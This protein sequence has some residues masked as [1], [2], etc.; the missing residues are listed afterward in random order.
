MA[1]LVPLILSVVAALAVEATSPPRPISLRR[2][3][4]AI[5]L[6]IYAAITVFWFMFSWRPWLAGTTCAASL[7]MTTT[8]N[9]LKMKVIGEP[10]VFSDIALLRQVPQHPELYYAL[11]LSDVRSISLMLTGLALAVLWY[12]T[13]PALLPNDLAT[14]SLAI[15]ALPLALVTLILAGRLSPARAWFARRFPKPDLD[16]DVRRYGIIATMVAYAFRRD[17]EARTPPPAVSETGPNSQTGDEVFLVLQ[18][19]SFLDPTR[20]GL[21]PLPLIERIRRDSVQYGRLRVS[22]HGAYTMRS[23]HAV[24][25]GRSPEDLGF[26]AFDPY[27]AYGGREPS[28]LARFA[29][30]VGY[31][32]T[33]VHPY[34]RDFFHRAEVISELGFERLLMHEA[35]VAAPRVGPYV[36]DIALAERI[37]AEIRERARPLFLFAVTMENHGPWKEGR[38]PG[39]GEPLTQYAHH[40][41][42]TGRAVEMVIEALRGTRATLCVFGDHPPS[43]PASRPGPDV[44]QTDYAIFAFGRDGG[45]ATPRRID[46]SAP[47]LGLT[48]RAALVG[49]AGSLAEADVAAPRS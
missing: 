42:N 12:L 9:R 13:E 28:S 29:S 17:T 32:T 31:A 1:F 27:L 3:D 19:E 33:F 47:Q 22:A 36:S 34:H 44:P 38:L 11:P 5:R 45:A 26:G 40:V 20:L 39:I 4:L 41:V 25:T 6:V 46:L 30:R 2:G 48:L 43:L 24:L 8:I 16:E 37:L 10:V 7:V 23:E 15:V 18:L 21:P 49:K 14:A 35:F